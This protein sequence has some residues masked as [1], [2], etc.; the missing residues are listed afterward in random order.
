MGL[1]I[2]LLFLADAAQMYPSADRRLPFLGRL[3]NI[4]YDTRLNLAMP[5][6]VDPSIVILDIDEK[7]LQELGHWPWSRDLL[8]RFIDKLF[9]QYQI[10]VVG[11]DVVFAEADY[12]SGIRVLDQFAKAEL[13]EFE[14]FQSDNNAFSYKILSAVNVLPCASINPITDDCRLAAGFP[15]PGIYG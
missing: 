13:K 8:A 11:F 14:G 5:R 1:A 9:D 12:S 15:N 4:L 7:S 10:A 2:V 3:D 6:G